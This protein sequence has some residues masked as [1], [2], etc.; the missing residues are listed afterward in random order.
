MPTPNF[1]Q[2]QTK[3]QYPPGSSLASMTADQ[4]VGQLM[5][6][7]FDGIAVDAELRRLITDY[8]IG[9]IIL[10]AAQCAIA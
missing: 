4:K 10:F 3:T 1:Y 9:G 6:I 2:N 5:L 8:H 7:G